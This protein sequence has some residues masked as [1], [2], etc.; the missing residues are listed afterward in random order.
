M[1]TRQHRNSDHHFG[2]ILDNAIP[3]NREETIDV[4]ASIARHKQA[5]WSEILSIKI[6]ACAILEY[7]GPLLPK[8]VT[9]D[10][11]ADAAHERLVAEVNHLAPVYLA[12]ARKRS[13]RGQHRFACTIDRLAGCLSKIDSACKLAEQVLDAIRSRS[14]EGVSRLIWSHVETSH[15]KVRI[16]VAIRSWKQARAPMVSRNLRLVASVAKKFR[17]SSI[18]RED[19]ISYG[20]EGLIV[21]VNRFD[22]T[23][24]IAF[25][26]FATYWIRH[27]IR[28]ADAKY[29]RTVYMPAYLHEYRSRVKVLLKDPSMLFEQACE[30]AKIP[31]KHVETVRR[32]D[33][34]TYNVSEDVPSFTLADDTDV[35]ADLDRYSLHQLVRDAVEDSNL[36]DDRE[37]AVIVKRF[38]IGD[39][40]ERESTLREIGDSFSV[41]RERI[42]QIEKQALGKLGSYLQRR[43]VQG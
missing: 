30:V 17:H 26:T 35:E 13:A 1:A 29:G 10:T 6:L 14:L 33:M 25:S 5:V 36:L 20:I 39:R 11:P 7:V 31:K 21:G 3:Y 27:A 18:D 28:R 40:A 41:S 42:R 23:R 16:A 2:A 9:R 22:H 38:N 24:G 4:C 43:G 19:L 34:E 32:M 37:R 15:A 12:N 8:P